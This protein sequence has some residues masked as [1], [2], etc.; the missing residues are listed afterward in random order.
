MPARDLFHDTV[1]H[2]LAKDGWIITHDPLRLSWGGKDLYVALGA[3]RLLAA[4]KEGRRIAV[5]VKSFIG[6]SL[7]ADLERALGQYVLYH[8]IMERLEPE[9]T[10][11]LAVRNEV[12]LD[13]FDEPVGTVLLEKERVRLLV[14]DVKTETVVKWIP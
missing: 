4:E 10:L 14:F 8:D 2:A 9:R 7:I 5:E 11:Y 12:F 3:E 6:A 13:L 1:R